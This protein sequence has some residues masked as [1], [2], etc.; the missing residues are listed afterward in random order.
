MRVSRQ[1]RH[2]RLLMQNGFGH[3]DSISPG[4]G[5]LA[6][7]CPACPQPGINLPET[8]KDD[9]NRSV[10]FFLVQTFTLCSSTQK[11]GCIEDPLWWMATFL[12]ST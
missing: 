10:T 3:D 7:F 4:D 9:P 1:W 2:L 8:W 6:L 11:D 12:L 5:D